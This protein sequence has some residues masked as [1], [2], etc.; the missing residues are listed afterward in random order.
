VA[1]ERIGHVKYLLFA[2]AFVVE[3]VAWTASAGSVLIR[4]DGWL[5]WLVS[6]VV[7]AIIVALWGA[8]MSPRAPWPL[9]IGWYYGCKAALYG[10]AA[11]VLWYYA[12]WAG[13]AFTA[14]VVIT[15]PLLFRYKLHPELR[16]PEGVLSRADGP[17]A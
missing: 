9:P 11:L 14:V 7:F 15:E 17:D 1:A 8:A 3:L 5:G 13:M 4:L 16:D 6:V 10:F 2:A 12:E